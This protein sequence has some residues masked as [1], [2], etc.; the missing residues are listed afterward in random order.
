MS[1]KNMEVKDSEE[2]TLPGRL[3]TLSTGVEQEHLR[4]KESMSM[5]GTQVMHSRKSKG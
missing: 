5:G 3:S 1:S 2:R 4:Q